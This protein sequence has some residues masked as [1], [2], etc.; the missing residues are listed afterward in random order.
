MRTREF[1][2][3]LRSMNCEVFTDFMK[4][5]DGNNNRV[6]FVCKNDQNVVYVGEQKKWLMK[7]D[8]LGFNLL[9]A[10]EQDEIMKVV[11]EYIATELKDRQ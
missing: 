5:S 1:T 7:N 6:I 4:D 3:T 9:T 11:Q 2:D 8:Y 10:K